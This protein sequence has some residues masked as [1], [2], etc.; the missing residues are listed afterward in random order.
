[1]LTFVPFA[2]IHLPLMLKW[3]ETPHVKKWWDQD[4]VWT[5]NLIVEKYGTYIDGYK[6]ENGKR[7]PMHAFIIHLDHKPIGYIQCYNVH[8]FP[9]EDDVSLND[10]PSSCAAL[11][12]FI[13]EASK[14]GKG[15]GST[16]LALF[17]L[18]HVFNAF[19]YVFLDPDTENESA[20]RSYKK[21]G[22]YRFKTIANGKVTWMI[23]GKSVL[24][25]IEYMEKSLLKPS[26][27]KDPRVIDWFIDDD[28]IE[29][30]C[31]GKTYSKAHLLSACVNKDSQHLIAS[32]L[33]TKE[34]APSVIHVNYK[35]AEQHFHIFRSS[36]WQNFG[37]DWR[38]IFHQATLC[39][40]D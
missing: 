7:K 1:M 24:H 35:T 38:M 33:T 29:I 8:D 2:A 9:R 11:D 17:L 3:L 18:E 5:A 23:Q 20:I 12:L 6:I 21:A 16:A 34:L 40:E 30:A 25:F 27:G 26:I 22:F 37:H 28:F 32:Q 14:I 10:L 36:L 31:D 15:H 19:D 4:V 13:G 39:I